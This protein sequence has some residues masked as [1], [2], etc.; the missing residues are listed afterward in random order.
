M[1]PFDEFKGIEVSGR[2]VLGVVEAF[3]QFQSIASQLLLAEKLG[4]KGPDGLVVVNPED[5]YA[6]DAYLRAFARASQQMGDA[7]LHQIGVSVMKTAQWPTDVRDVKALMQ[8]MDL[9]HYVRHR[10]NGRVMADPASGRI[11][12]GVGH[13]RA[14]PVGKA[15]LE[16]E[17]DTPYPCAYDKGLL[18]GGLRRLHATGSVVHD[19]TQSCRKKGQRSCVYLVRL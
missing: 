7:V 5:W 4:Q 17:S 6:C 8:T 14:R 10:K 11:G 1:I 16:V 13:Y 12:D 9:C 15:D 18:F 19:A 3:G 2:N